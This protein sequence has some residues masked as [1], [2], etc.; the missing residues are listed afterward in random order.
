[1]KRAF[2]G[3]QIFHTFLKLISEFEY[4][5][6]VLNPN[7]LTKNVLL[8]LIFHITIDIYCPEGAFC[9]GTLK[10][11]DVRASV[12]LFVRVFVRVSVCL[13]VP[14]RSCHQIEV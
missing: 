5:F 4:F 7:Y 9:V 8:S 10:I 3:F 11:F 1:M 6:I 14:S 12:R 13:F 2:A